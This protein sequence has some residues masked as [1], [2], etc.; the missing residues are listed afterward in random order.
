MISLLN[1]FFYFLIFI[2]LLFGLSIIVA[3]CAGIY[4]YFMIIYRYHRYCEKG[5]KE[6]TEVYPPRREYD[7]RSR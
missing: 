6:L 1:L 5:D 2:F 3:M 4:F 7:T